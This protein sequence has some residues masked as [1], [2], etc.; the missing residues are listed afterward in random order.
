MILRSIDICI[1]TSLITLLRNR[2]WKHI[3]TN[4]YNF[5][6]VPAT[7]HSWFISK[8]WNIFRMQS[9]LRVIRELPA[10]CII[11]NV[12]SIGSIQS[13]FRLSISWIFFCLRLGNHSTTLSRNYIFS[14]T[15]HSSHSL[16]FCWI[17]YSY[18]A[19]IKVSNKK[20]H[21]WLD[22]VEK[23]YYIRALFFLVLP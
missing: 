15:I 8:H 4:W 13:L 22:H 17:F 2:W 20:R 14:F 23:I 16:G 3:S 21:S 6:H 11:C 7:T 18:E 12:F 19:L 5:L 10:A 9:S 1:R